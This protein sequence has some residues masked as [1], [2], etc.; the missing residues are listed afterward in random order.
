MWQDHDGGKAILCEL[1]CSHGETL[2]PWIPP[3]RTVTPRSLHGSLILLQQSLLKSYLFNQT[4]INFLWIL[5]TILIRLCIPTSL[6]CS[7]LFSQSWVIY[8][9]IEVMSS[10]DLS[11]LGWA[12]QGRICCLHKLFSA[13]PLKKMVSHSNHDILIWHFPSL[14]FPGLLVP[15]EQQPTP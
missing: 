6:L 2:L 11:L 4:H 5:K 9:F 1:L 13:S 8:S 15:L 7:P 12:T 10:E 3:P 14:H